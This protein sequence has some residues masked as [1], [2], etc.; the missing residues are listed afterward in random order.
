MAHLNQATTKK[1][2]NFTVHV[3]QVKVGGISTLAIIVGDTEARAV[4]T[5]L[6]KHPLPHLELIHHSWKCKHKDE[7]DLRMKQHAMMC[8]ESN[9]QVTRNGPNQ[10]TPIVHGCNAPGRS[11]HSHCGH[12]YSHPHSH[13][14]NSVRP[15]PP[16][17][18][19]P[20]S[21]CHSLIP[22]DSIQPTW[23]SIS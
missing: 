20:R 13:N 15:I 7:F 22:S 23:E 11:W 10:H 5:I 18:R 16:R 12:M 6:E 19:W 1:N 14:R 21:G 3:A 2:K 9:V 4:K 17:Q 8:E